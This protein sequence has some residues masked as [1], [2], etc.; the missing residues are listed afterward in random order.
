ML[1]LL[2]MGLDVPGGRLRLRGDVLELDWDPRRESASY[3]RASRDMTGRVARELGGR[4]GPGPLARRKRGLT[5]HSLGGCAMG[6]SWRDG[7]VDAW[8]EV[9]GRGGLFVAD[10]SV[11]PGPVG[12]N[13]GLTIAAVA[14]RFTERM[15]ER[16]K[17]RA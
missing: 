17:E 9:F 6:E 4:L 3:F 10:G 5:V 1:P 14:D 12:P 13:P 16:A 7:V 15:I 2:Q 8:G 11:M